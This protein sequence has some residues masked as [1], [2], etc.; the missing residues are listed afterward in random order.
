MKFLKYMFFAFL[1]VCLSCSS[2]KKTQPETRPLETYEIML[3]VF[4][5]YYNKC[6]FDSI[7]V[8]DTLDMDLNNWLIVPLRDYET[9]KNVSQYIYIKSLGK[10]ESIYRVYKIDDNTYKITKRITE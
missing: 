4:E 2:S 3:N 10:H 6:Q 1:V 8:A 5:G 7:C 9:K